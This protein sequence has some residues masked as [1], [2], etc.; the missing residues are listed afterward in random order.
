MARS[1]SASSVLL[2]RPETRQSDTPTAARRTA[3]KTSPDSSHTRMACCLWPTACVA[4]TCARD[5]C[6]L[7]TAQLP[8]KHEPGAGFS[9]VFTCV[10]YVEPIPASGGSVRFFG[11]LRRGRRLALSAGRYGSGGTSMTARSA[12]KEG[13]PDAAAP[14]PD[15][16]GK[17]PTHRRNRG[18]F[19]DILDPK[20]GRS[21]AAPRRAAR[22]FSFGVRAAGAGHR[23]RRPRPAVP[24]RRRR[25]RQHHHQRRRHDAGARLGQLLRFVGESGLGI[26]HRRLYE[27]RLR[28]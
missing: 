13:G 18:E 1:T 14:R 23:V 11:P 19:H 15:G 6:N 5:E 20:A 25:P 26:T 24:A 4:P 9:L 7:A 10:A 22:Y 16:P 21:P 28:S 12:P 3:S 8:R 2:G 17:E 27:L